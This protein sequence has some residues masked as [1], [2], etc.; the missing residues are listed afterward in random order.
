MHASGLVR[1]MEVP[2]AGPSWTTVFPVR[3]TDVEPGSTDRGRA[4]ASRPTRSWPSGASHDDRSWCSPPARRLELDRPE[5]ANAL[6]AA[7]VERLHADL[8]RAEQ[9]DARPGGPAGPRPHLLRG[10]RP[11]GS[12]EP[13]R[14]HPAAPP[15]PHP[16][17]ARASPGLVGRDRR[18]GAR[19]AVGAGPTSCSPQTCDWPPLPPA[20]G[21]RARASVPC[22]A[23]GARGRDLAV[24]RPRGRDD[25]THDR[26][27]RSGRPRRVAPGGFPRGGRARARPLALA[28]A[29]PP[30]GTVA[31]G[32]RRAASLAGHADALGHLVRS[33]ASTPGLRDRIRDHRDRDGGSR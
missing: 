15:H 26:R 33:L 10:P 19:P 16:A 30:E 13:D 8:D 4:W 21:S 17:V 14:R 1:P 3:V 22:S 12:G 28:A 7:T 24:V 27:C 20:C 5:R 18:A 6:D 25:R 29:G 31:A 11:V 32:L 23:P 2:V 9:E